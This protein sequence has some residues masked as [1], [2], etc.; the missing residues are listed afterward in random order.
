MFE[1]IFK[2]VYTT[3]GG[4]VVGAITGAGMAIQDGQITKEAVIAGAIIGAVGAILKD[5]EWVKRIGK[6]Q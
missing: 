4:L 2:N 5:P 3:A 1:R 6:A